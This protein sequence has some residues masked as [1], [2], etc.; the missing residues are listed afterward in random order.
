MWNQIFGVG[1]LDGAAF[2][3]LV[4][5]EG[6]KLGLLIAPY[7]DTEAMQIRTRNGVIN[8]SNVHLEFLNVPRRKRLTFVRKHVVDQLLAPVDVPSNWESARERIFPIVR[9]AS[10]LVNSQ[11]DAAVTGTPMPILP[12]RSIGPALHVTL[13]V[14]EPSRMVM[15]T[16]GLLA[17][18]NVT[19]EQ[20]Y[21]VA[22]KNLAALSHAVMP[23]TP[24]LFAFSETDSYTTARILFAA[25]LTELCADPLVA[26]PARGVMMVADPAIPEARDALLML[27]ATSDENESYPITRTIYQ[28][29]GRDLE[30]WTPT[31][32]DHS[33][34]DRYQNVMLAEWRDTYETEREL[35]SKLGDEQ[36]ARIDTIT[37]D[38]GS[39]F[40]MTRWVEGTTWHLPRTELV[41]C[42]ALDDDGDGVYLVS[43]DDLETA[44]YLTRTESLIPRWRTG[45]F[46][47]TSWL[48]ANAA[49][50]N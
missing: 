16:D 27:M 31:S 2:T 14:D 38:D 43:W 48:R 17:D 11:L 9:H 26:I 5:K 1:D 41:S 4:A 7:V 47:S 28:L 20:A 42:I 15:V 30:Q 39:Y 22:A 35:H 18:W 45:T 10:Y 49:G 6:V 32:E 46:P 23:L 36:Y 37:D 21:E 24:G 19:F 34:L 33:L 29:R 40:T 13:A 3:R 8:L 25:L 50:S 12:N 44:G